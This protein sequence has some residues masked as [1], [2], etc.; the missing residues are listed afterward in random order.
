MS[1]LQVGHRLGPYEIVRPL[2]KGGMGEI[3]EALDR[4]LART[5]A[6]KLLPAHVSRDAG[7]VERFRREARAASALNHPHIVT[8]YDIGE[9][10]R[11]LFIAMELIEGRTLREIGREPVR[12]SDICRWGEQIGRALAAS[13]QAGVAHRDIKP[14]NIMIRH[15]GYAKVLDFGLASLAPTADFGETVTGVLTLSGELMGTLRYMSP[16]QARGERCGSATDIFSLGIVL[17]ELA[18]GHHPFGRQT[19]LMAVQSILSDPVKP[20]RG[21]RPDLPE[22]FDDVLLAMLDKGE[23]R[24][25]TAADVATAFAGSRSVTEV[26]AVFGKQLRRSSVGRDAEREELRAA[27]RRALNGAGS[28]ISIA[29]EPGIGKSTLA[30]DFLAEAASAGINCLIARGRCSERLAGTE[31]YLPVL[32]AM[33]SMLQGTGREMLEPVMR[34]VSPSWYVQL[35]SLNPA[36]SSAAQLLTEAKSGSQERMKRELG[37]FLQE[38]AKQQPLILFLDDL[39]WADPSTTDVLSYLAGRINTARILLLVTYR[40][41]EMLLAKHPMLRVKSELQARGVLKEL[42]LDFLSREDI[43]QYLAL[44]FPSHRFSRAIAEMIH[45]KTE[46]NALFVTDLVRYLRDRGVIAPSNGSWVVA[47]ELPDVERDLPRSEGVV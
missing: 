18:T 44:E 10:E 40:L 11:G 22:N 24:R 32:E 30:E 45:A 6:V 34:S 17:Y 20:P 3:Y 41:T 43:E 1:S 29:G 47:Q 35:A 19:A 5:V 13:H 25:P 26:G 8:I 27:F 16:E 14:E 28:V 33:D 38:V 23:N 46:G 37:L 36:D 9:S 4:R 31:A 39:H 42:P 15:D 2:G 7:A 21:L 12:A